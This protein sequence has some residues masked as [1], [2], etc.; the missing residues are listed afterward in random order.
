VSDRMLTFIVSAI[1]VDKYAE[2]LLEQAIEN[3]RR[4]Y[5]QSG[6][7][8]S[9][10]VGD[11]DERRVLILNEL[12]RLNFKVY[13]VVVDKKK[14]YGQGFRYKQSFYKKLHSLVDRELYKL[15]PNLQVT[16]D[17][18]GT[19]EFME[20]FIAYINK[21]HIPDLFNQ[22]GFR[23]IKS[24]HSL[25]IQLADF[26]SGTLGRCFDYNK[27][28]PLKETFIRTLKP[29]V[30]DIFE[31]PYDRPPLTFDSSLTGSSHDSVIA[32]L[33]IN[34]ARQFISQ[35]D[36]SKVPMEIDQTN[37]LKFLLF[38]YL[39]INSRR[40]VSTLEIKNHLDVGS[41]KNGQIDHLTPE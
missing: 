5:F 22:S 24:H 25:I 37:C 17:E 27:K 21:N 29:N 9:S 12:C 16:S 19:K 1:L 18:H 41:A 7:M 8:K 4:K 10:K 30:L 34:L 32:E 13:A 39:Q 31:W 36:N 15:F 35:K 40:F 26:I 6:E 20:G 3:V 2:S 14:L 33:S 38:Y 28:S 11:N 23:F